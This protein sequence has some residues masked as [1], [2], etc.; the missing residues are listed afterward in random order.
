M[1]CG[2]ATASASHPP[3]YY[4]ADGTAQASGHP[5][6]GGDMHAFGDMFAAGAPDRESTFAAEEED[7][8][9]SLVRS[10]FEHP[11]QDSNEPTEQV[12]DD[13]IAG[14]FNIG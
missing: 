9:R 11:D 3:S 7:P 6:G 10:C 1:D 5:S 13:S 12:I 8:A 2:D 4:F 14:L